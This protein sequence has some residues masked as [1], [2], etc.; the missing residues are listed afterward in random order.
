MGSSSQAEGTWGRPRTSNELLYRVARLYYLEDSTQA[1]IAKLI[2]VSRATVSRLLTEARAR[3][4]VRIEVRDPSVDE[5]AQ[6]ADAVAERLGLRAVWITP[7]ALGARIGAVLAPAVARA[8][9][10]AELRPGDALLV[11]SGATMYAVSGEPLIPLPGVLM[12]PTVGG[13]EEESEFYQTNEITRR[14]AVTAGGVPVMLHAPAMPGAELYR[15]LL[16]EPSIQRVLDMWRTAR[17]ALLGIGAPPLSR[18]SL[19][20]VMQLGS[21]RLATSVGDL[22]ARPYDQDG[23][24]LEFPGTGQLVAIQLEDLRRIP[25]AIGV[26]V[27]EEKVRGITAAA[28]AG[29]INALVTDVQTATALLAASAPAGPGVAGTELHEPAAG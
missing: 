24:P 13:L 25:H 17:C 19:P 23:T 27:G 14:L 18:T 10:A 8:L 7:S 5:A 26:A 1:E 3:D 29:Y 21:E 20:S 28:R 6:L 22:C 4:I 12:A 2:G 15:L 16:R 11:S 9:H